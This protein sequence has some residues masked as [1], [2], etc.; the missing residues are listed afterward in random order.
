LSHYGITD[1]KNIILTGT[2]SK[3][4]GTVG[5]VYNGFTRCY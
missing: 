5:G 3:A 1:R 4:I 2:L